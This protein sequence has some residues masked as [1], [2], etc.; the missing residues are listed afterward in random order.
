MRTAARVGV[1]LLKGAGRGRHGFPLAGFPHS[2]EVSL[3]IVCG[4]GKQRDQAFAS[5]PWH[6]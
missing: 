6:S 1:H 4:F 3:A 2:E 5:A